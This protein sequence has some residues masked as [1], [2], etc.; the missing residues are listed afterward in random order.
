MSTWDRIRDDPRYFYLVLILIIAF[1]TYVNVVI[2]IT[3]DINVVDFNAALDRIDP[4]ENVYIESGLHYAIIGDTLFPLQV[5]VGTLLDKGAHIILWSTGEQSDA[6]TIQVLNAV[7]GAPYRESPLYGE[8]L[9]DLGY[10]PGGLVVTLEHMTNIRGINPRDRF[11]TSLD[12]LPAATDFNGYEDINLAITA[13]ALGVN[14]WPGLMVPYQEFFDILF[15]YH[16]G[17]LA[18][19]STQYQVGNIQ[20]YIAGVIQGAQ[21][22]S[23]TGKAFGCMAYVANA[24]Y[25]AALTVFG[26]IFVMIY[27]AARPPS[28]TRRVAAER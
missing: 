5:I 13:G 19:C 16:S 12:S 20:G 17:G 3:P 24:T 11:G 25:L 8:H 28:L 27:S 10:I 6:I 1:S 26:M 14:G 7:M 18:M 15:L 2:P 21:L 23:L 22:E 9:I 4:G